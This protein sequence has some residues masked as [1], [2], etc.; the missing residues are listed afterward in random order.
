MSTEDLPQNDTQS[1]PPA[2]G[3]GTGG[4]LLRFWR[5]WR[6]F[7]I[8]LVIMF[9]FRSA[10]AD[11]NDVPSGS[12]LPT[13]LIGDRILVDKLAYDLKFPFTTVHLSTWGAP[14]R[15][16]I[17]VFYS[18]A[19]GVRL[20][21]RVI[22][23]PGDQISMQD[24]QLT[25]NGAPVQY[26]S[27]DLVAGEFP[28]VSEQQQFRMEQLE[29]KAHRMLI[30]PERPSMRSFATVTVPADSFLM[31]GDNRDNSN[32]SRYIGFVPRGDILGRASRVVMSLDSDHWYKPRSDRFF[33]P[34]D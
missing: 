16:D 25:I 19:D 7:I 17:V 18:P 3:S 34:L 15:G 13:I 14:K 21:K 28:G 1:K 9:S 27:R 29:G 10:I 30:T 5:E 8:F 2:S 24:N 31:M 22:G 33:A 26:A 20:V 12:M 6:S 32:D 4:W 23:L 11:W